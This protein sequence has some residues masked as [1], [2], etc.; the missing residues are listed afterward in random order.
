MVM[1]DVQFICKDNGKNFIVLVCTFNKQIFDYHI[2]VNNVANKH[3]HKHL[4]F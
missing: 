2:Y 4:E 1:D 3:S